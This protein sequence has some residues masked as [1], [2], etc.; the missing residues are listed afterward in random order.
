MDRGYYFYGTVLCTR[1]TFVLR[2]SLTRNI[3]LFMFQRSTYKSS[4]TFIHRCF[5]QNKKKK[6]QNSKII[7]WKWCWWRQRA[8]SNGNDNREWATPTTTDDDDEDDDTVIVNLINDSKPIW[9]LRSFSSI[10]KRVEWM[11]F[12]ILKQRRK[13]KKKNK[14]KTVRTSF[15]D[16]VT[17]S[18][19]SCY[20]VLVIIIIVQL[21]IRTFLFPEDENKC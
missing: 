21:Q 17:S 5:Q 13:W 16:C 4:F 12:F 2:F 7:E 8:T 6:S 10:M 11:F 1:F 19:E 9:A 15:I 18:N 20:A 14:T 3:E